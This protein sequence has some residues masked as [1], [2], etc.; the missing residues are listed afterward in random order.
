MVTTWASL[1]WLGT[2]HVLLLRS[3]TEKAEKV[4]P[5]PNAVQHD[6][7]NWMK[8]GMGWLGKLKLKQICLPGANEAGMSAKTGGT[9]KQ[10]NCNTLCQSKNILKQLKTGIRYLDLRPVVSGSDYKAGHYQQDPEGQWIGGDGQTFESIVKQINDFTKDHNE[11]IIASL[12]K[13]HSVSSNKPFDQGEWDKLFDIVSKTTNLYEGPENTLLNVT[14][15][16]LTNK[17]NKS[18][19]LYIVSAANI[20]LGS[21]AG[22]GLFTNKSMH[23]YDNVI[24][25][26]KMNFMFVDQA[27]KMYKN[28]KD[29]FF[30]FSWIVTQQPRQVAEC[31]K[32][33]SIKSLAKKTN[34]HMKD[35]MHEVTSEIYPNVITANY[36]E[37]SQVRE[38]AMAINSHWLLDRNVP[39]KGNLTEKRKN[40]KGE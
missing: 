5:N 7:E 35:I 32:L 2:I 22:K 11:L 39:K 20:T 30:V 4:E 10:K 9:A 24:N 6:W 21:Y 19:V 17:G 14:L 33:R 34:P 40:K 38:I 13:S 12:S 29:S 36:V 18:A 31:P 3:N 27:L 23:L 1:L 26:D 16:D 25:T 37:N 15:G 8:T 28:A